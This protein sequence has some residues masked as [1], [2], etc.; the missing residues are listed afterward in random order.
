MAGW[1]VVTLRRTWRIRSVI[2]AFAL[3]FLLKKGDRDFAQFPVGIT[4]MVKDVAAQASGRG[5]GASGGFRR[6]M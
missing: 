1:E 2:D 6:R 4:A 5:P 3:F